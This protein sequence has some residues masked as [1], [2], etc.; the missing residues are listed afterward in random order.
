MFFVASIVKLLEI[1]KRSVIWSCPTRFVLLVVALLFVVGFVI[2]IFVAL[3]C[4]EE[5]GLRFLVLLFSVSLLSF[6]P[7]PP[8]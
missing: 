7:C 6:D 2:V 4:V 8:S 3:R 5:F 1:L